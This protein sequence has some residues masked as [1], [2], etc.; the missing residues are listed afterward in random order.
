MAWFSKDKPED[1]GAPVPQTI[2]DKK[3][4]H[5]RDNL[6]FPVDPGNLTSR[7]DTRRRIE[8][9]HQRMRGDLS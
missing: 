1:S 7:E 9:G 8:F 2:S 5:L 3:W 6:P 4:G